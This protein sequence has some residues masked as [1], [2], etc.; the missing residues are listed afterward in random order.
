MDLLKGTTS[1]DLPKGT[2][3]MDLSKG[4]TIMH[5]FQTDHNGRPH[6]NMLLEGNHDEGSSEGCRDDEPS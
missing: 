3:S 1:M 6:R 2:M 5:F 4:T